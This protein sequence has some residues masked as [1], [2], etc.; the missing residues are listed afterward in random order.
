MRNSW[1][2]A[3]RELFERIG[4]RSFILLSVF[5]PLVLLFFLYGL[6]AFGG[7]G[8]QHWDVLISDPTGIMENKIMA[9]EDKA[10][11]Y[12]FADDY[13][14]LEEFRDAKQFQTFDAL[15]EINE[16]VL[17]NKTAFVF[18][19]E[20]PSVRMQTRVQFQIERRLE[21]LLAEQFT[22]LSVTQFRSI[23]QALNMAF[24]NVYDPYDEASDLRAWVGY[25]YGLMIFVFIF[26]F[27]MTILRSVMR[28]KSSRIVE[29]LLS[30]VHPNQLLAGK[31]IGIGLAA[32]LQFVVWFGM[33]GLGLFFMR[34]WI[35]VDGMQAANLVE[36][37]AQTAQLSR[38]DY[39]LAS[40]EYNQFIDLVFNRVQFFNMTIFFLLFFVAGY[41]FYGAFF[42]ALGA[43]TGSESDGQQFV[44][45]LVLLLCFSMYAG[46]Y[47]LQNPESSLTYFFQYLP[48][49]A[50]VVAMV[51]LAIGYGPGQ[52]YEIYLSLLILLF[53][54]VFILFLAGRLYKNG[55]LQY[56]HRLRLGM[57]FRWLKN[58]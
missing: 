9:N 53:S 43:S 36:E 6:F 10:V 32:F 54:A 5:G 39:L 37:T 35:F 16:K 14:E 24:R 45:P 56:G 50:P 21:E 41:V 30:S 57:L 34:E 15:I 26:L 8:K 11:T 23:K 46:Y 28:D 20:N 25:F 33:I 3:K 38:F 29:V 44:I 1:L 13:I 2:L 51:K 19:R 31:I 55:I 22:S 52:Q 17:S 18:Y 47:A 40:Q 58:H 27:G 12:S 4:N 42:A 7:E 48:F 49:T